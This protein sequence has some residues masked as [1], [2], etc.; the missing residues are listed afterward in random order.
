[1][2]RFSL[3]GP[4]EA[5]HDGQSRPIRSVPRR[6]LLAILLLAERRPVPADRLID[7]LWG[8]E[9]PRRARDDLYGYL[10]RLRAELA[11]IA[12]LRR[13]P[14]GY[15]LD[16]EPS[17]VDVH[18]F[19]AGV[20]AAR[21]AEGDEAADALFGRAL[22]L[23]RGEAFAGLRSAW[24]DGIRTRLAGEREAAELDHHDV[25]L[26]LGRHGELVPGLSALARERPL[27]ERV[28]GQLVL[29]LHR[30]G[31]S[32]DALDHY[33]RLRRRLNAEFGN[34]PGPALQELHR[35]ILAA[36][37]EARVAVAG[38][39]T[40]TAIRQ[41]PAAPR[42][43]RGRVD[44]LRDLDAAARGGLAVV[45][46]PG[47]IG[48]T[49][50][51]L[52]WAH[53]HA[54]RFGDGQL[55]VDL[56]GFDPVEEPVPPADALHLLL[57]SLGTAPAAIPAGVDAR[58][59]L[60][61]DR[62]AGRS[63]LLLLDNARDSGQVT[64]L[65]PGSG[66]SAV[67]VTSRGELPSLA[68]SHGAVAVPLAPMDRR[69]A[70]EI[71]LAHIGPGRADA[72]PEALAEILDHCAGLPLAL[73]ILAARAAAGPRAPLSAYAAEI[74]A[75]SL[76]A[77]DAGET[78]ANLRAVLATSLRRLDPGPAE[79]FV[80]F[81]LAPGPDLGLPAAASLLGVPLAEARG[82]MAALVRTGLLRESAPGRHAAH[83]LTRAHAAELAARLDPAARLAAVRRLA[84]YA[85]HG[86]IAA[87]RLLS[88]GRAP[89]TVDP[90]GEGVLTAPV[91]DAMAWL[92]TERETITGLITLTA[93]SG[94]DGL[95][96]R[97]TW[98]L[99]TFFARAGVREAELAVIATGV[100]AAERSG[101]TAGLLRL[102][103]GLGLLHREARRFDAAEA[104]L[105]RGLELA[106]DTGDDLGVAYFHLALCA[107]HGDREAPLP[108][109]AHATE[110]AA[111]FARAGNGTGHGAALNLIAWHEILAGRA[112]TA[113]GHARE[114]VDVCRAAGARRNEGS[115]L[116]TLGR[117]LHVLGR[118]T[119]AAATLTEA[120]A[121]LRDV[122]VQS[123]L[124][125]ALDHLSDAHLA[126]GRRGPARAALTE[127]LERYTEQGMAEAEGARRR[128]ALMT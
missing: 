83:D 96:W 32:A 116:D 34:E 117:A 37:G 44:T 46:G 119:E 87:E 9:P 84:E 115:A 105:S 69:D 54:G 5:V 16:A 123:S 62:L 86:A 22:G 98:G 63:F 122:G 35:L 55:H 76:G 92:G 107:C 128:L 27:D 59:A 58:S 70:R 51:A 40:A 120:C 90:P 21:D 47:G 24:L 109:I 3:L 48:K 31:R 52:R 30:S 121:I 42:L 100:A 41:L 71:L 67:V 56:R 85:L 108:A 45:C 1:M 75:D 77:L 53:E 81:G 50:L 64:P 103:H 12:D 110:A 66:P 74:A 95:A 91:T 4:V 124:G 14:A 104:V 49:W 26:R 80:H 68:V 114:A 127:A 72:E 112:A 111:I 7:R 19:R 94:M 78:G 88:P 11:G 126:L 29:A 73:G 61:R 89:I 8:A 33:G 2:A 60:L 6:A 28:A 15:L 43:F 79:A 25:R 23:W 113:A 125:L 93:A 39:A 118:H 65:L 10:S 38:P 17:T 13:E 82:R 36:T 101:E 97:L 57:T 99:A 18:A 20:A 102:L 106:G